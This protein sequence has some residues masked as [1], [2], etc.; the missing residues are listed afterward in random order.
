MYPWVLTL[1]VLGACVWTGGHLLLALGVLPSALR[2]RDPQIVLAFE[3]RFERIGLPA[4]LV[5]VISGL[6][7]AHRLVPN[8]AH[9]FE[10]SQPVSQNIAIKLSC[11]LATVGLAAHARLRIIP[12]LSNANLSLLA[13]HIVMVTLLGVLFVVAGVTTRTGGLF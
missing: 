11:L 12:K 5:Q 3:E 7:L 1:H 8:P 4:L 6:W 13:V 2:L 9:W 10:F